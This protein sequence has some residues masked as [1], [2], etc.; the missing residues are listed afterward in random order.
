MKTAL[1]LFSALSLTLLG[2]AVAP[3][4]EAQSIKAYVSAPGTSTDTYS[5]AQI[6]TF[7]SFAT[8]TFTTLTSTSLAIGGTNATYTVA[9][10]TTPKPSVNANDTYSA[11]TTSQNYLAI[12]PSDTVT[13]TLA[14][15]VPYVGVDIAALDNGNSVSFYNAAGT[16]ISTFS[17]ATITSLF[18]G[19]TVTAVNGTSYTTSSY[20]GQPGNTANNSAQYYA[21]MHFFGQNGTTIKS[22]VF[23]ETAGGNFETENHSILTTAPAV[24]GSFVAVPEPGVGATV[25]A[26]CAGLLALG[27]L[28]RRAR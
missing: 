11:S 26:G 28:V 4:A 9:G 2:L 8:G 16:L 19:T 7:N 14:S 17:A 10:T 27:R 1:P 6:E 18:S 3:R 25:A 21:Y 5:G 13:L 24:D 12:T 22:I 15:A 23:S 20:K